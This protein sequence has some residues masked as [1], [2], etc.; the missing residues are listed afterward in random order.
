MATA[1]GNDLCIVDTKRVIAQI[2]IAQSEYCEYNPECVSIERI[3]ETIKDLRNVLN[4]LKHNKFRLSLDISRE[5]IEDVVLFNS[6]VLNL[7]ADAGL[8]YF[9]NKAPENS[10]VDSEY[11]L[12]DF[13]KDI[14]VK[15]TCTT[16]YT[17]F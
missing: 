1:I 13:I 17:V 11:Y 4:K 7:N 16:C 10:S 12:S 3:Q 14:I 5:A 15:F 2:L 8:V 9:R 6:P